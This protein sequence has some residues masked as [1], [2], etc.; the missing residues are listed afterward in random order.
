MGFKIRHKYQRL[1]CE[2]LYYSE[3][4]TWKSI[5]IKKHKYITKVKTDHYSIAH[6]QTVLSSFVHFLFGEI[7]IH[8]YILVSIQQALEGLITLIQ[9]LLTTR[10][11]LLGLLITFK[12][13]CL[14]Q[15]SHPLSDNN[16]LLFTPTLLFVHYCTIFW[17]WSPLGLENINHNNKINNESHHFFLCL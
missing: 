8:C 13:S 3:M 10:S 7:R 14:K 1:E 15:V 6:S 11:T 2:L 4:T 12:K 16:Y 9:M 17:F 5:M